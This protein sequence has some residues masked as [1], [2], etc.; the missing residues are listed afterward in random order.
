MSPSGPNASPRP[1]PVESDPAALVERAGRL[2]ARPGRTVLGI[3]GAPAA[4]KS[5]L[6]ALLARELGPRAALLPMD[7]YHLANSV[8]DALG[9]RDRKGAPDTFDAPG[10]AALLRRLRAAEDDAGSGPETVYAPRFHRE[11]EE[12]IAGE[13]AIGPEVRL[14]ITEGN[15][16][17]LPQGPWARV[18]PL[19]DESW[20][21]EP[22]EPLRLRRL[23]D[24]HI[25]FG[26][27]PRAAHAWA[28][29]TDQRNAELIATT[30]PH[31]DL[32]V[33]PTDND[34]AAAH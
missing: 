1:H 6:A 15:Y 21:V 17:L 29:G 25:Q 26:K 30:R 4:G 9:R 31:A 16:L 3:V 7:G 27:P 13:I 20:Y 12:S 10:Y 22:D 23:V 8:L 11:I 28:H 33:R 24:R 18:R 5:T 14:V 19:L 32:V 2:M 34:A